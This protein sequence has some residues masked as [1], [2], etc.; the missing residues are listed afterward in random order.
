MEKQLTV[1]NLFSRVHD[2]IDDKHKMTPEGIDRP[3][4]FTPLK[5][6]RTNADLIEEEKYGESPTTVIK[7]K[8]VSKTLLRSIEKN[9]TDRLAQYAH[10]EAVSEH[11]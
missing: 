3:A 6:A 7:K 1:A 8:R 10:E 4:A 5:V 9:S 11:H 2:F